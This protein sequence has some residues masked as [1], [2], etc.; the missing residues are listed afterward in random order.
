MLAGPA[1]QALD[2]IVLDA[3]EVTL[4]GITAKNASVRLDLLSDKQ[5]RIVVR[6]DSAQLP[7]PVGRLTNILLFCDSPVIAEPRFGCD[8]GRLSG[9]GGRPA[10]STRSSRSA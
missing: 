5:T 4:A 1:A 10:A 7:D 6:A 3:R 8:A 2:A 9:R